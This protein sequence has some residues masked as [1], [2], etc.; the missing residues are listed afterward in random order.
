MCANHHYALRKYDRY[1]IIYTAEFP[2]RDPMRNIVNA[3]IMEAELHRIDRIVVL[4]EAP[5]IAGTKVKMK[6]RPHH[7]WWDHL[8]A[9]AGVDLYWRFFSVCRGDCIGS[10]DMSAAHLHLQRLDQSCAGPDHAV[11]MALYA[12]LTKGNNAHAPEFLGAL[13]GKEVRLLSKCYCIR[14]SKMN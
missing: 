13:R 3:P 10:P 1:I 4:Q 2:Q 9:Q 14:V 7:P 12:P 8:R 11:V 5:T 6:N